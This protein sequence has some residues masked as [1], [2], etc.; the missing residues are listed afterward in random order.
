MC[1]KKGA[2]RLCLTRQDVTSGEEGD[3]AGASQ[4]LHGEEMQVCAVLRPLQGHHAWTPLQLW[5]GQEPW[6]ILFPPLLPGAPGFSHPSPS[7][8]KSSRDKC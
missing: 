3:G 7:S 8:L 2:R 6:W 1:S 5:L 4:D